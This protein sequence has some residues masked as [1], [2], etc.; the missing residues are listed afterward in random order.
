[1]RR[2]ELTEHRLYDH[3]KRVTRLVSSG[4][5]QTYLTVAEVGTRDI[6]TLLVPK[7]LEGISFR[8]I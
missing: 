5:G 4:E 8:N 2:D 3:A 6:S 1:M 7:V